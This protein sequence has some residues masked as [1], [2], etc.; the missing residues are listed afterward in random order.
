MW[1]KSLGSLVF[2]YKYSI[3]SVPFVEKTYFSTK[4]VDTYLLKIF[5]DF[6]YFKIEMVCFSC[7]LYIYMLQNSRSTCPRSTEKYIMK[8]FSHTSV[9]QV[10]SFPPQSQ[11][12]SSDSCVPLRGILCMYKQIYL[13]SF[14]QHGSIFVNVL[15]YCF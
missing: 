9:P 2:K 5:N 8:T 12:H 14:S 10:F 4:H 1:S 13:Y 7:S 3:V 6:S 11:Q 15:D